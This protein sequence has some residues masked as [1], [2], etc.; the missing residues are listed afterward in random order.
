MYGSRLRHRAW[1]AEHFCC[2]SFNR[3]TGL[4]RVQRKACLSASLFEE[5]DAV[6]SVFDRNLG[7]QQTTMA[8]L[9]NDQPVASYHNVFGTNWFYWR[10]YADRNLQSGHF[11]QCDWHEAGIVE[12]SGLR[13]F[14][15]RAIQR[16]HWGGVTDTAAKLAVGINRGKCAPQLGKVLRGGE[17]ATF[18]IFE[19]GQ[20]RV[21]SEL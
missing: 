5:R 13:S 17:R 3:R 1:I 21:M 11:T 18:A 4:P 9:R 10:K 19:R 12:C 6:P 16:H 15:D 14:N 20:N 2:K 7:Q 8:S